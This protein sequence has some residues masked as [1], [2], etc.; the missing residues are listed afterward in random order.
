MSSPKGTYKSMKNGYTKEQ[1][2]EAIEN[3]G[4]IMTY[5]AKKLQCAWNTA[6]KYV[7]MWEETKQA[8]SDEE[9]KILDMCQ[10]T[11]YSAVKDGD[12][13]SAK[14]ILATKGKKRGFNEKYEVDH[15][16]GLKVEM[17]FVDGSKK[18]D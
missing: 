17:I 2:L 14:W 1:V 9:E 12:T 18:D 5:V 3:S 15:S 6:A 13:Q 7:A 11:V 8:F 16:G 10:T 4:G